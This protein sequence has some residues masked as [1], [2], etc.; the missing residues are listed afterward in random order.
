MTN[1]NATINVSLTDD[2][3]VD[4]STINISAVNQSGDETVIVEN[5]D[6]STG[7]NKSSTLDSS[8]D[9]TETINVSVDLPDGTYN[10]SVAANDTSDNRINETT[11]GDNFTVATESTPTSGPVSLAS[12]SVVPNETNTSVAN[13]YVVTATLENVDTA[14]DT[15]DAYA[16][17]SFAGFDLSSASITDRSVES[18]LS[19]NSNTSSDNQN[20]GNNSGGAPF[21]NV[22]W[23]D[24]GGTI[25]DTL[26]VSFRVDQ[27]EAPSTTG[28]YPIT[29]T[30]DTNASG[31][32][33][34]SN[35]TVDTVTVGSSDDSESP[36]FAESTENV[37]SGNAT[38]NV[39]VTDDTLVD[40]STIDVNV[41]NTSNGNTTILVR[42]GELVNGT[43]SPEST[44]NSSSDD[45][46]ETVNVSIK[47]TNGTYKIG[48]SASDPDGNQSSSEAVGDGF[49]VGDTS[50]GSDSGSTNAGN[51]DTLEVDPTSGS[52]DANI[53]A[54]A[55]ISTTGKDTAFAVDENNDGY[56]NESE[57]VDTVTDNG[58]GD[59][60]GSNDNTVNVS[61][62]LSQY[63][64]AD[65]SSVDILAVGE[66]G[67]ADQNSD[68][69]LNY[70]ISP[71][72][73]AT[74]TVT[75]D[76]IG[77][78]NLTLSTDE[79][80]AN[81]ASELQ[82]T[83][84]LTDESGDAV[85]ESG[86]PINE[87]IGNVSDTAANVTVLDTFGTTNETGAATL[88][89]TANTP[90]ATVSINASENS[91]GTKHWA[92][93][94]FDTVPVASSEAENT[95]FDFAN[96]TA[97][98]TTNV[99]ISGQVNLTSDNDM[100]YMTFNATGADLGGVLE[101]DVN[102]SIQNTPYH[103]DF[104]TVKLE[105]DNNLSITVSNSQTVTD[106]DN[107]TVTIHNVTLP[108]TPDTYNTSLD[109]ET[110]SEGT[111]FAT[112][113]GNYTVTSEQSG[114]STDDVPPTFA[115]STNNVTDGNATINVSVTDAD[116]AVNESTIAVNVTNDDTETTYSLVEN[117]NATDNETVVELTDASTLNESNEPT[118]YVNVTADLP[119]GNY[120]ISASA[121]DTQDNENSS[122]A[123]GDGFTVTNTTNDGPTTSVAG[124]DVTLNRTKLVA[125]N[126]A[127]IKATAQLVDS[128]GND[129]NESDVQITRKISNKSNAN[130]TR[131]KGFGRTNADGVATLTL[132]A[133]TSG[134]QVTV[135]A[136]EQVTGN[137]NSDSASFGTIPTTTTYDS[138]SPVASYDDDN[139][140]TISSTE[141]KSAATDFRGGSLDMGQLQSAAKA[142]AS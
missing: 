134:Y 95:V 122:V 101:D 44:F 13:S 120:T 55:T 80:T 56:I 21:V 47:L 137:A 34:L 64:V 8:D 100:Q 9:A 82:A 111:S 37:T 15:V 51:V 97:G 135:T 59:L 12:G 17:F 89:L 104:S 28:D 70:G 57:I 36:T 48:A 94:T 110:S 23:D 72:A 127:V 20:Y 140:G 77:G 85:S 16:N 49:T 7:V 138:N 58:D 10:L 69:D 6:I 131:L 22:T 108:E 86:V 5:G 112:F 124:V 60:A 3:A 117:G 39:S 114:G 63:N 29:V 19:G 32:V 106:D 132:K 31:S 46:T 45:K 119:E 27:A 33:E 123:V 90:D 126:Q 107:V 35:V 103:G 68:Y 87:T 50:T 75:N 125:D 42:N 30:A 11:L 84:Q 88:N 102:L 41:T 136:T 121:S 18:T 61:V 25:N 54:S 99:T 65:L 81:N 139:D 40:Q 129:V 71:D 4:E 76:T 93:A 53:T 105:N 2:V 26:E 83:A 1:D 43:E 66:D 74:Y 142:F 73:N 24:E 92:N 62:N 109:L 118:E 14:D 52:A 133:N 130:I 67:D 78:L 79:L 115:E 96:T 38:V 91:T 113:S 128:N 141:L 98:A 116:S